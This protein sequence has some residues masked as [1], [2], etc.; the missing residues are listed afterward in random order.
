MAL[1]VT[2]VHEHEQVL[3]QT[4][5]WTDQDDA[6]FWELWPDYTAAS[7]SSRGH[8]RTGYDPDQVAAGQ[9]P[10]PSIGFITE[11]KQRLQNV[12]THIVAHQVP[13]AF[14]LMPYLRR[15]GARIPPDIAAL[16]LHGAPYLLTYGFDVV[17]GDGEKLDRVTIT[18]HYPGRGRYVNLS[19]APDTLL[20]ESV[21]ANAEVR[22]AVDAGLTIGIPSVQLPAAAELA[23]GVSTGVSAGVLVHFSYRRVNAKI[24][25]T[26]VRQSE[27]TWDFKDPTGLVGR[28]DLYAVL[29]APKTA[30]YLRIAVSGG[31]AVRK[32]AFSLFRRP[33]LVDFSGSPVR[34]RLIVA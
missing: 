26:G 31:F 16:A 15:L 14:P 5:R 13:L 6:A 30:K 29:L 33:L 20:Q 18:L 10:V 3:R 22:A 24:L 2:P 34:A 12:A 8:F 1:G 23:G 11:Q 7:S 4:L 27:A 32:S 19:L 9:S 28:V 25:T 21:A 17:P